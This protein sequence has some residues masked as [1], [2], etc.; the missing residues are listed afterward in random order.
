M[1]TFVVQKRISAKSGNRCVVVTEAGSYLRLIDFVSLNLRLKDLLG[2][3]TRVKKKKKLS[4]LPGRSSFRS[5]K[6]HGSDVCLQNGSNQGQNLALTV[7]C[8]PCLLDS[9]KAA[10]VATFGVAGSLIAQ[11]RLTFYSKT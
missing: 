5:R 1:A 4:S 11:V 7:V 2:P 10:A 8:V 6:K 3:V 9:G